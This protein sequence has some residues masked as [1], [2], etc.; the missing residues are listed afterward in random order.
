MLITQLV[1][2]ECVLAVE[3][4]KGDAE[5]SS[6]YKKKFGNARCIGNIQR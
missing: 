4:E 1:H 6:L 2:Y 5:G 3:N